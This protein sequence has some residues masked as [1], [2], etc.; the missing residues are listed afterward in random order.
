MD[1]CMV[2]WCGKNCEGYVGRILFNLL[3]RGMGGRAMGWAG[4]FSLIVLTCECDF[5]SLSHWEL[6]CTLLRFD[7][8]GYMC[9]C[10]LLLVS[11]GL[12]TIWVLGCVH[13]VLFFFCVCVCFLH[14]RC[15][16]L[17]DFL[18]TFD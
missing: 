1:A 8:M 10:A 2:C 5:F 6:L 11:F 13:G 7:G 12:V 17:L 14:I 16:Y 9:A 3:L 15:R 4:R 18:L